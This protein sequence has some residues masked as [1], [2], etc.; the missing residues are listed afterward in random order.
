MKSLIFISVAHL[1][2]WTILPTG[3]YVWG[4][5]CLDDNI[6][7]LSFS[8]SDRIKVFEDH[9]PYHQI[10]EIRVEGFGWPRDLISCEETKQLYV[11][12]CHNGCIWQIGLNTRRFLTTSEYGP[13]TLSQRH[14]QL[15]VTPVEG[16][17]LYVY[18]VR[19]GELVRRVPLPEHVEAYH[20]VETSAG[21]FFVCQ[22]GRGWPTN[23]QHDK[24]V[25]VDHNGKLLREYGGQRGDGLQQ[26]N[27]PCY[28]LFLS[29]NSD[30]NGGR[31]L[32]ADRVNSRVVELNPRTLEF[33]QIL[34]DVR[35]D[36]LSGEPWRL[37]YDERN[38]ELF[39]GQSAGGI[40]AYS[41]ES[42]CNVPEVQ[43]RGGV[44]PQVIKLD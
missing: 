31:L 20:A 28:L 9:E 30:D 40:V 11:S 17:A 25:E 6:F 10:R 7:V 36:K 21:T 26:L 35:R 13:H 5:A 27:S 32:V 19:W 34:L 4:I 39:V 16:N 22:T 18:H 24:V 8:P 37:R 43:R 3:Q 23:T 44:T 38:E 42:K 15:T 33:V 29:E 12:D 14:Q 41:L 1:Q 2:L